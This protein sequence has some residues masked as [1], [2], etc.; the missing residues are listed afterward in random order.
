MNLFF[1]HRVCV[2]S[3]IQFHTHIEIVLKSFIVKIMKLAIFNGFCCHHEMFGYIIEF[4]ITNNHTLDVYTTRNGELGWLELYKQH[5]GNVSFLSLHDFHNNYDW[6]IVTTDDDYAFN[7]K[8]YKH[9][10]TIDHYY[11]LRRPSIQRHIGTRWFYNRPMLPWALPCFQLVENKFISDK[12]HIAVI[13]T[14]VPK[15]PNFVQRMIRLIQ[16]ENAVFHLISRSVQKE[17]FE[18][19]NNIVIYQ[20]ISALQMIDILYQT[21]YI[22]V[23]D[24]EDHI[25]K[26]MSGCIPLAFSTLNQLVLPKAMNELYEFT[27]CITYD[28][29]KRIYLPIPNIENVKHERERL[30]KHRDNV[31]TKMITKNTA[32]IVEPRIL[33]RIPQIISHFSDTLGKEWNIVFYC[34]KNTKEEWSTKIPSYVELRELNVNNLTPCTYSDL[35]KSKEMWESF[36]GEWVLIFQSDTWIYNDNG[37]TIDDYIQCGYSY[38]GGNMNYRWTERHLPV[39]YHNFNGGLSLRNRKDMLRIIERF[40]PKPTQVKYHDILLEEMAEDVYFTIGGYELEMRMGDDEYASHFACHT[41]YHNS[42]FGTHQPDYKI[43]GPLLQQRPQT[44]IAYI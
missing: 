38:I 16:N 13:G 34:G 7:D 1:F 26:K 14:N 21:S 17:L 8:K 6:I 31:F 36:T 2:K 22:L 44:K 18:K 41:I 27:S 42:L 40:P 24:I 29:N 39:K 33:E 19:Y 43:K 12:M 30:I 20:S 37:Y 28:E 3:G 5:F 9:V 23:L 4:A 10:I 32:V 25:E 35:L 11:L 15:N